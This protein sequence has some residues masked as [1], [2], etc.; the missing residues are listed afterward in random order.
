MSR[1]TARPAGGAKRVDGG[2]DVAADGRRAQASSGRVPGRSS[3][4]G[5]HECGNPPVASLVMLPAGR[6][7]S[8]RRRRAGRGQV[9]STSTAIGVDQPS[10]ARSIVRASTR[11][12]AAASSTGRASAGAVTAR[13]ADRGALA[14]L[15]LGLGPA[16]RGQHLA[17]G[18]EIEP[19]LGGAARPPA[20]HVAAWMLSSC[21]QLHAS[22][23]ANG[24]VGA[25]SRCTTSRAMRSAACA[26]AAGLVAATAVGAALDQLDV[27]VAEPPEERLG[28]L[29]RPGVVEAV[30]RRRRVGDDGV[31]P[32]EHRQV[33]GVGDVAGGRRRRRRQMPSTNLLTLSS[34][35]ASRRPTFIWS[36]LNAVSTPGPG[37]R[38]PSSGRRRC[39]TARTAPS[40]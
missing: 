40:A 35:V 13:P 9:S 39:R 21:H 27:V 37:R 10:S 14:D 30:E 32:A 16:H 23:V 17:D 3:T 34:L 24:S 2:D 5:G 33:D 15:G 19:A 38:R 31:E 25:S 6:A 20:G 8:G 1:P 29:E 12:A 18:V 22:S 11:S 7:P 28:A 26:D 4:A 36:S